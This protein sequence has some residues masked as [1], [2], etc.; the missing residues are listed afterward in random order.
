[1][2]TIFIKDTNFENDFHLNGSVKYALRGS[3]F[4]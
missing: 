2:K 4:F 3:Q 1:M